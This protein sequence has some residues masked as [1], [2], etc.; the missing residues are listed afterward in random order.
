MLCQYRCGKF[1]WRSE[2]FFRRYVQ[3][4]TFSVGNRKTGLL[5]RSTRNDIA[6]VSNRGFP[7]AFDDFLFSIATCSRRFATHILKPV[8][9]SRS[10]RACG[11]T[12]QALQR[13]AQNDE[14]Y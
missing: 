5:W 14:P 9:N 7:P 6:T 2:T 3:R 8:E 10:C 12:R 1:T 4:I 11:N 13:E